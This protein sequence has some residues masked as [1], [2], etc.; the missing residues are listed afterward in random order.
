MHAEVT[1]VLRASHGW[2][3]DESPEPTAVDEYAVANPGLA[4]EGIAAQIDGYL[5]DATHGQAPPDGYRGTAKEH[6]RF[7]MFSDG[8]KYWKENTNIALGVIVLPVVAQGRI[9]KTVAEWW[10][11]QEKGLSY[12]GFPLLDDTPQGNEERAERWAAASRYDA[13]SEPWYLAGLA[14]VY[15]MLTREGLLKKWAKPGFAPPSEYL[16]GA[17]QT[18]YDSNAQKVLDNLLAAQKGKVKWFTDNG[19]SLNP[20]WKD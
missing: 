11:N 16:G 7:K 19:W 10:E 2:H 14:L 13:A 9:A 1:T 15:Q 6:L 20:E 5:D 12:L 18:F 17:V 4:A 8:V 3:A